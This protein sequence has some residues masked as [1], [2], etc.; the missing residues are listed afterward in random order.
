VTTVKTVITVAA[1]ILLVLFLAV[2]ANSPAAA[3]SIFQFRLTDLGRGAIASQAT[4]LSSPAIIPLT[5]QAPGYGS[6]GI[7][8]ALPETPLLWPRYEV[9]PA[10]PTPLPA[11]E[12]PVLIPPTS[13]YPGREDGFTRFFSLEPQPR[14][15]SLFT[16]LKLTGLKFS[17]LR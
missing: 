17:L 2:L 11:G 1:A 13:L 10:I 16:E 5:P 9:S 15:P 8:V 12:A 6:V 3:D 14:G 7:G 4:T